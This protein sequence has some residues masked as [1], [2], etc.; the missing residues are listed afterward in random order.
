MD[1]QIIVA[2][3]Y[4]RRIARNELRAAAQRALAMERPGVEFAL[5]IVL[6][7]DRAMRDYNK[8][9]HYVNAPTDVLSFPSALGDDYLGDIIISYD[10][11]KANA[12]QAGWRVRDELRLLVTHG[13]LHVLGYDDAT[14]DAR[15]RM[16]KRQ[17]ELMGN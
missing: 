3:K 13:V 1:I 7:S 16:W 10:T 2:P 14:P 4:V 9:F 17:A 6:V 12:K 5:T 11:A 15:E 8:R